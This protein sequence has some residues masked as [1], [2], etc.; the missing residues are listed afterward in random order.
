MKLNNCVFVKIKSNSINLLNILR[1]KGVSLLNIDY[2]EN[3]CVIKI[4]VNDLDKIKNLLNDEEYEIIKYHGIYGIID[5]IKKQYIFIISLILGIGI[6]LLLSNVIFY[7]NIDTDDDNLKSILYEE[8]YKNGIKVYSLKKSYKKLNNIKD[9]IMSDNTDL[10]EWMSIESIGVTY[11]VNITKRVMVLPK[12]E[13][14][15]SDIIASNDGIIKHIESSSGVILK[16]VDD[17]V[18]KGE[19]IITGNIIKSDKYLKG[20]V[21]SIGK[22]YAEV[23]Y[24]VD[25]YIPYKYKEYLKTGREYNE[26]YTIIFDKKITLINKYNLKNILY[27]DNLFI[28][29]PYLP[30]KIYKRHI[31]E[32]YYK[33]ISLTKK[34]AYNLGLTKS[35]DKIKMLL[36]NDEYIIDKKVLKKDSTSSKMVLRVFYKVYKNITS[37]KEIEKRQL[38]IDITKKE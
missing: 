1:Y 25:T 37:I 22:V 35:D 34:E 8:L 10:L 36:K 30:F 5:Y 21:P 23:W 2:Y 14:V 33:D 32:Y 19:V 11:K 13:E 6:L 18:K 27:E 26:Y 9:K 29:K 20:Q 15:I 3:Y 17:Y 7:I 24:T 28:E 31:T 16:D 38:G 4:R 12:K